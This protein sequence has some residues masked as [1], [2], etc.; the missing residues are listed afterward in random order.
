MTKALT[1]NALADSSDKMSLNPVQRIIGMSGRM[2]RI[3]L[4]RSVPQ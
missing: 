1:P 4:A 2:D 3:F